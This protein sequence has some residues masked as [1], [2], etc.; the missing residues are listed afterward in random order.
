MLRNR[1]EE[2]PNS[3]TIDSFSEAER[4]S[5]GEIKAKVYHSADELK[6]DLIKEKR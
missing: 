4:I 2:M 5:S 1:K 6:K 3:K